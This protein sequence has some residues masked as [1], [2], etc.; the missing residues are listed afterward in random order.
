MKFAYETKTA[1]AIDP[2]LVNNASATAIEI[3]TQGFAQMDIYV[4]LGVTDIALTALK[5]QSTDTTGSGYADLSGATFA[6]TLPGATDDSKFAVFHVDLR[7]KQ[8][9]FKVI[10]TVGNG[11]TGANLASWAVLSRKYKTPSSATLRNVAWELSV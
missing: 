4:Y 1:R 8:R 9:F 6:S 5:L 2:L 7:G 11:S 10:A 3:D